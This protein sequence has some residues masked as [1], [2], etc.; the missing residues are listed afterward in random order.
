[1]VSAGVGMREAVRS[2]IWDWPSRSGL[3]T[4][5]WS[6]AFC[7]LNK[8][9]SSSWRRYSLRVDDGLPSPSAAVPPSEF[10]GFES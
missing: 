6:R 5:R 10:G 8:V 9:I 1:L 7:S 3:S 4:C 2:A